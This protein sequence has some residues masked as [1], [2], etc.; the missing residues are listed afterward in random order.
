MM[1]AQCEHPE[2]DRRSTLDRLGAT[3]SLLCAIHCA[4]LPAVLVAAPALG[5][6]FA[7]RGFDVGFV[8]FAT[9]LGLASLLSAY[10]VHGNRR[11]LRVLLPGLILLWSG[12][13]I[14]GMQGL[15]FVHAGL[16][17][18]GGTLV[19]LAH[20]LNLRLT[21]AHVRSGID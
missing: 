17:A 3:G 14:D 19:A 2:P 15:G 1:P 18:L 4:A 13:G 7:H 20:V 21:R 16:M 10:R 5:A 11:A 9:A 8:A 12:V 6:M